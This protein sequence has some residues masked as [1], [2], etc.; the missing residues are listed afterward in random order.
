M[1]RRTEVVREGL[2]DRSELGKL[3]I[4]YIEASSY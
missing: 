3:R 2:G 1:L 4:V